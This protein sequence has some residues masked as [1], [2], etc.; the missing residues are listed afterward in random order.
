MYIAKIA[1]HIITAGMEL[2]IQGVDNLK[3]EVLEVRKNSFQVKW[4]SGDTAGNEDNIP[5]SLFAS[6]GQTVNIIEILDDGNPN[7][8]FL[9]RKLKDEH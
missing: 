1:G 6:V 3:F 5:H 2:E 4:L 7:Q 8:S 9:T